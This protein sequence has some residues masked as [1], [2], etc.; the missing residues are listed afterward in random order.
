MHYT[1]LF[2]RLREAKG[3]TLEE[4]ARQSRRHRNTVINVES[5][6]PV[7]FKTIAELMVKMGYGTNSPETRSMALLWL[8][9][10]TG[11]PFSQPDTE[12]SARKAIAG[13]RATARD[14]GRQLDRAVVRAGLDSDQIALLAFAARHPEVLSI[15]E[16]VRALATE[17]AVRDDETLKAAEDPK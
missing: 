7:K 1:Q 5:G 16:N 10:I 11:I 9:A 13:Y 4:L 15:L 14:A 12:A 6:R 2:R 3:L 17:F 8:E